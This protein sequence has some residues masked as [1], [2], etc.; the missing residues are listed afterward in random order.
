MA[1][2]LK[3]TPKSGASKPKASS[4]CAPITSVSVRDGKGVER[5]VSVRKI[6]NGYIVS[7]TTYGGRKGYISKE[8]FEAKPPVLKVD[9]P[10][11]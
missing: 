11:K 2:A 4:G 7:E 9:G 10:K 8:R 6:E 1:K 5:S 3:P